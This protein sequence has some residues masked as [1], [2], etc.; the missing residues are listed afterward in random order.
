MKNAKKKTRLQ[1]L[2]SIG[3][4]E[5]RTSPVPHSSFDGIHLFIL[6]WLESLIFL[7]SSSSP[8]YLSLCFSVFLSF[9]FNVCLI[10]VQNMRRNKEKQLGGKKQRRQQP[11]PFVDSCTMDHRASNITVVIWRKRK[12]FFSASKTIWIRATATKKLKRRREKKCF[13]EEWRAHIAQM[14]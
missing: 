4:I 2:I 5:R 6:V 13:I 11:N 7:S 1:C 14:L 9:T 10:N 3:R 8:L 12:R